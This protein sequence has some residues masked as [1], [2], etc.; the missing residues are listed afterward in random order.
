MV[1]RARLADLLLSYPDLA[2]FTVVDGSY[3]EV[4]PYHWTA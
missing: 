1:Q 4:R 3:K 2:G